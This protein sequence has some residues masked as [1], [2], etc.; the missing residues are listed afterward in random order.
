MAVPL[1]N[2][3][4]DKGVVRRYYEAQVRL[5]EGALPTASQRE[6]RKVFARLA[7][8]QSQHYITKET[9]NVL[10]LRPP[11][12][13][14]H[15]LS[16]TLRLQKARYLRRWARRLRSYMFSPEDA[17][18]LAYCN[19]GVDELRQLPF[20]EA[21]LTGDVRLLNNFNENQT[22]IQARFERMTRALPEPFK[23]LRLPAV[24]TPRIL[25]ALT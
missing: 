16:T 21:L 24:L 8:D 25:L 2:V 17:V 12:Y 14:E 19:F 13:A 23:R 7:A 5:A 1:S 6:A 3:L 20:I 9:A 10:A 18:M 4:L 11:Q 15:I 22:K